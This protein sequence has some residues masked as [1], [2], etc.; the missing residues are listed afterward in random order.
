MEM[1]FL[2]KP[3]AVNILRVNKICLFTII[4]LPTPISITIKVKFP[5][6]SSKT[7]QVRDWN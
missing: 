1:N 5:E 3:R 6:N 4:N 2:C 7:T